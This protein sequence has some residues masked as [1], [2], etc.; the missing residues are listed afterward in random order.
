[1]TE[2]EL[3]ARLLAEVESVINRMLTEKPADNAMSL[4]DIER[5]VVRMDSKCKPTC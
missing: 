4:S 1:M 5:L 3:R 2:E